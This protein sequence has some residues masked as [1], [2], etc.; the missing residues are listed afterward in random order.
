[1]PCS[2]LKCTKCNF[3]LSSAH[4]HSAVQRSK[5]HSWIWEKDGRRK[6]IGFRISN[7]DF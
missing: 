4:I 2:T 5:S 6:S 1:M 7:G 3:G